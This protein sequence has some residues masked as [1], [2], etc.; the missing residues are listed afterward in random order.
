L[1]FASRI[2]NPP[3]LD[4]STHTHLAQS[5]HAV[6]QGVDAAVVFAFERLGVDLK[7]KKRDSK[8][9]RGEIGARVIAFAQAAP[10]SHSGAR[11]RKGGQALAVCKSIETP[12]R[13]LRAPAARRQTGAAACRGAGTWHS[14]GG[15]C[16]TVDERRR[17]RGED[18]AK[19]KERKK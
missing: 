4:V 2:K 16:A 17:V 6:A 14:G 5:A 7:K 8:T 18:P 1:I 10:R 9:G 3:R 19:K 15:A 13:F 12:M 11:G